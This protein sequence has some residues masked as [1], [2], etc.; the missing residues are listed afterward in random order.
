VKKVYDFM[1]ERPTDF[2]VVVDLVK[3]MSD[4][5]RKNGYKVSY[6]MVYR[7]VKIVIESS[8]SSEKGE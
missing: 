3:F 4:I 7:R 5:L 1:V 6:N 8:G 2:D